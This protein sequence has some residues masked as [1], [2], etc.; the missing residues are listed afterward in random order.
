[1]PIQSLL[2]TVTW[3]GRIF[4]RYGS[5]AHWELDGAAACTI[6]DFYGGMQELWPKKAM[7]CLVFA[8]MMSCSSLSE[9]SYTHS[10]NSVFK[11][12]GQGLGLYDRTAAI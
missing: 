9:E 7:T 12:V 6:D 5:S 2:D 10:V 3:W 1:M 11:Q 8:G 4:A